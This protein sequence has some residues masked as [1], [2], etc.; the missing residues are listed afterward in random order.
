M[1]DTATQPTGGAGGENAGQAAAEADPKSARDVSQVVPTDWERRDPPAFVAGRRDGGFQSIIRQSV[2]NQIHR[3]GLSAQE[4]EVCGVLVGNVYHDS[5]G[6]WL[7]VEYAIEG[8][9]ASQKAAQVTFTA[10]TWTHI[11]SVMDRE[12]TDKRI[13]GWYHTHPGFGIFLSDMDLFIQDNFFPEPWQIALVYD[14]KAKEEGLFLWKKGRPDPSAFLIE[15]DAPQE[16]Q[17]VTVREAKPVANYGGGGAATDIAPFAERLQAVERRQ[18]VILAMLAILTLI[19]V[20]WPLAVT[21]F[22][23]SLLKPKQ[24]PAPIQLPS[25]DPTSRPFK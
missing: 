20:A 6:P 21:A 22:L 19:A 1:T 18:K 8:N 23:P 24:P 11:Q 7:Y 13:L 9:H 16:E 12:Y 4:I 10:D 15:V 2:L 25:D 17:T 5:L 3:H 14:P